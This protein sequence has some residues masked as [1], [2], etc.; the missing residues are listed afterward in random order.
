MKSQSRAPKFR[1]P[2]T[3]KNPAA[4]APPKSEAEV[5]RRSAESQSRG[6]QG[7]RPLGPEPVKKVGLSLTVRHLKALDNLAAERF[8]DNRSKALAAVLD[9][10]AK[11]VEI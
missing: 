9:G 8:G 2:V 5:I 10:K 11:L 3:T 1:T 4:E 7:G 6:G